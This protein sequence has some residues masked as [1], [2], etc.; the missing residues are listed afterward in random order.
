M[1][2]REHKRAGDSARL[3]VKPAAAPIPLSAVETGEGSFAGYASLFGVADSQGD[4]VQPGAF[5]GALAARGASRIAMLYQHDVARPVGSWISMREDGQGLWVEGRLALDAAGGHEAHALLRAGALSG[6]SIGFHAV[7]AA[8]R[9]GGGRLLHEIDLWEVSLVTF[10]M[11]DAARVSRIKAKRPP[12]SGPPPGL[13]I[14]TA[15]QSQ[16]LARTIRWAGA[17][18]SRPVTS[19][20]SPWPK[21]PDPA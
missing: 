20:S 11:L 8:R 5:A 15:R 7:R 17:V 3:T 1:T 4:V 2:S 10:P 13:D 16:A 12:N 21:E 6:L 9:P 14:F 18:L 19:S